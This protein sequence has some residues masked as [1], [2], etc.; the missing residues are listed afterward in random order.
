MV[1]ASYQ[2]AALDQGVRLPLDSDDPVYSLG[3]QGLREADL[4]PATALF[5]KNI[6]G[7]RGSEGPPGPV[8]KAREV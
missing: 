6:F 8:S 4:S 7:V 2:S 5:Q 3:V 1:L